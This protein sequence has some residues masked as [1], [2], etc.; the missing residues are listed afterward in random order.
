MPAPG[1]ECSPALPPCA[2]A[3][4]CTMDRPRP[5]PAA[6]APSYPG[7]CPFGCPFRVPRWNRSKARDASRSDM[8]GPSSL[9]S[10]TAPSPSGYSRTVA[11]VPGGVCARTLP[12]RFASTCRIRDSSAVTTSVGG[13]W[14]VSWR[15]GSTARASATAS[16]ARLARSVSVRSSE[17]MRSRRA[18][19]S[20]SAT[21]MLI[22]SASCSMRRSAF[23][24][25]SGPRAPARYSSA[26]PR[27]VVSGVRSSWDASA[28]NCRTLCSDRSRALKA[29]WIRSSIVLI[30]AASRPVS[31]RLPP[32]SGIRAARSPLRVIMSAVLAIRSSGARPRPISQLPQT[33]SRA[34]ST[35]P[36]ISSAST[37]PRTWLPTSLTGRP[38]R[39]MAGP[40][41]ATRAAARVTV[42]GRQATRSAGS[43]C[44]ARS[45]GS[46]LAASPP[47]YASTRPAG[48]LATRVSSA[49]SSAA[50]GE[51]GVS[52][53]A[54]PARSDRYA[55][56]KPSVPSAICPTGCLAA[57]L[58]SALNWFC[59]SLPSTTVL[60][61]PITTR[62]IAVSAIRPISSRARSDS[63]RRPHLAAVMAG[64]GCNRRRAGCGSAA[65]RADRACA[66]G[67]SRT[68]RGPGTVRRTPS[69]TRS[70]AAACG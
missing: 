31:W 33:A 58:S 23:G 27:I 4:A 36:V 67:S 62:N 49:C 25:S 51:P 70:R 38:T 21:S 54:A 68:S 32:A 13:S 16:L 19:S 46:S 5:L 64:G 53:P 9:T 42:T 69:P 50:T 55:A 10:S 48:S 60:T 15:S 29:C 65:D 14:A 6:S 63:V 28:A 37:R 52:S 20:S 41:G 39:T 26:Y 11:G 2:A 43:P 57:S 8:P 66:A 1:A 12:S 22:R 34:S 44:G 61:T 59:S 3:I 24:T 7:S 47:M 17:D 18:S 45:N 35:P 30:A 40:S 56:A